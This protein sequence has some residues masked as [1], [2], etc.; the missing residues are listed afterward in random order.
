[1]RAITR[2]VHGYFAGTSLTR[3][4][5]LGGLALSVLALLVVTYLPQTE[6]MLAFALVGQLA[7]FLGSSLMPLMA[8]RLAQ[9]HALKLIPHGRLKLLASIY[10]T[11]ALVALPAGLLA[12]LAFIAGMSASLSDFHKI[13]HAAEYL[14]HVSLVTYTML[15]LLSGWLY[16]VMW[17]ITS[18][19]NF[20]GL[21]KA[22][23]IIALL[24]VLPSRSEPSI[25]WNLVQ[26]AVV[27]TV[28]GAGF[29]AW[30]RIRS[31]L[32]RRS[33]HSAHPAASRDT[34]GKEVRLMLGTQSPWQLVASMALPLVL[35]TQTD[36]RM[37][38]VWLLLFT[39]FSTVMGAF[40]GQAATRSRALWLRRD[41]SRVELFAEVEREFWRHNGIVLAFLVALFVGVA[42]YLHLPGELLVA[43]MPLLV[44]AAALSTYLGLMA[45]RGL[46]WTE[47]L[48]ASAVMLALMIVA[49]LAGAKRVDLPMVVAM[50]S[51][52]AV[53]TFVLRAIARRR[54]EHIDWI[55]CRPTRALATRG[56]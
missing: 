48:A 15:V 8:G 31:T 40:A 35:V 19:R 7:L 39:V 32:W 29:L 21:A 4:L 13:P 55:E 18:Q 5:T 44:L 42:S 52:L 24:V 53:L 49:L 2:L 6:H 34:W 25:E 11:M 47:V 27:W 51:V 50:E 38:E 33:A 1:M 41:S 30:P 28:F 20:A 12:P 26:L 45:T 54:W 16:L 23:F 17:F 3:A 14:T 22:M 46:R 56:A 36:M 43:G 37:P 9:G 10:L